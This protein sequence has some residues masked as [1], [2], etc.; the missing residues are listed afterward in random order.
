MELIP[1]ADVRLTVR[2]KDVV[3]WVQKIRVLAVL[4]AISMG[5]EEMV[6]VADPTPM[7]PPAVVPVT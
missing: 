7:H 4:L 2:G 6:T 3:P 1:V 5:A